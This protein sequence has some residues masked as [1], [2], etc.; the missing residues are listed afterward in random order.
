MIYSQEELIEKAVLYFKRGDFS[1]GYRTL[2]DAA[3]NTDSE[4]IYIKVLNFVT[5]YEKESSE[6]KS[7]L[8]YLFENCVSE[9]KKIHIESG[10][11]LGKTIL[12]AENITKNYNN[13]RFVLGPVN[14]ELKRGDI[15]GLVG[16]NG[17]GK[18]TLLTILASLVE[19]S[20]GSLSYSFLIENKDK[21]DLLSKLVY[22][23]QRT[24]V[25][26]GKVLDNL[27]FTLVHHGVK[28][29]KN[30]L[31]VLM[32][33]ARFGLW[34]YKDLKWSELSSGYKM[35]FELAR[36]MLRRP[37][38]ILLDEPLANL[39]ILAQQVILEDLRM[40]SKSPVNPIAMVFSSQQL[41]EVEK[42]SDEVI[43]LRN[44][45]PSADLNLE[46]EEKNKLIVEIDTKNSRDEI[47]MVF[48]N[49]QLEKLEFNGGVYIL[50]FK[51][52]FSFNDC[53]AA[54]SKNN[55][56]LQYI[57]DISKS[58]RRFFVY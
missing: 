4:E 43:Y 40:I 42:I 20:S 26:Y 55:F 46:A 31:L 18:T 6:D 45:K 35:R 41:Y 58:T 23:P 34:K 8:L 10:G 53:L 7:P 21:Y 51:E 11:L 52:G 5:H 48:N 14:V 33:V 3:L 36:T 56:S 37:E 38:I 57:R 24:P 27:K 2:L 13:N 50:Y 17:N 1:L 32:M 49:N 9:I 19:E 29:K 28:G 30:N 16:E 54:I 39:D 15:F 44:G 47:V 25:W 22:I 12:K